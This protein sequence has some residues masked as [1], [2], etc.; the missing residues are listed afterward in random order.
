MVHRRAE[1]GL[2]DVRQATGIGIHSYGGLDEVEGGGVEGGVGGGDGGTER[3]LTDCILRDNYR[4]VEAS[5]VP[6]CLMQDGVGR[7]G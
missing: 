7:G 2:T 1:G 4:H 5:Q 3:R 6:V